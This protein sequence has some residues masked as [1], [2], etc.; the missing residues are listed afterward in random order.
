M[1]VIS[2]MS[3]NLRPSAEQ[4]AAAHLRIVL[5]RRLGKPTQPIIEQIAQ[6]TPA[7]LDH[8]AP[9]TPEPAGPVHEF[10][11]PHLLPDAIAAFVAGDLSPVAHDRAAA[12]IAQCPLC[13]E[14]AVRRE[15]EAAVQRDL[16]DTDAEMPVEAGLTARE[17]RALTMIK[18][19]TDRFGYPPSVREIGEATGLMS[20]SSVARLLR[21]L[22]QKGY[23]HRNP[24]LP[25]GVGTPVTDVEQ[26][27]RR[28][29]AEPDRP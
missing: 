1:E 13:A 5:D 11:E 22:E 28:L 2:L 12:H 4:V 8:E 20:T 19:Y 9:Q 7:A 16:D 27:R 21:S 23:L 3:E 25:R 18:D 26:P 10:P 24:N 14:V 15:A 6:M 17:R 29:K